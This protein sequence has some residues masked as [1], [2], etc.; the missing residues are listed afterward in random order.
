V[1]AESFIPGRGVLYRL[2]PRPKLVLLILFIVIFF[3]E[4]NLYLQ[5]GFIGVLL[6]S[7]GTNPGPSHILTPFRLIWP[8]LLLTAVLTPPFNT[9]GEVLIA[10]GGRTILTDSGALAAAR[11]IL[12]F[13][14]ITSAFFLFFSTT[15]NNSLILALRSF[16]L[17]FGAALTVTIALRY[18]PDMFRVYNS[19]TDAHKLRTAG[20]GS[21]RKKKGFRQRL[22]GLVPVLVSVL[23]QAV[24]GI[25]A[26]SMALEVKGFGRAN[27]RTTC[28]KLP[29]WGHIK[30][31]LFSAAFITASVLTA[32][33][34]L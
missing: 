15:Q 9:T 34:L 16:G 1:I 32:A 14:G 25:P 21:S 24:K 30:T 19:I 17:P 27:K 7:I 29:A 20:T 2:D 4:S 31:D 13:S 8:I 22:S 11:M 12:R 5:A 23:I 26:L 3:S 33:F 6:I 28:I 18:I 10:A